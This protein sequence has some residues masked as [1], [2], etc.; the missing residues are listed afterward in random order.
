MKLRVYSFILLLGCCSIPQLSARTLQYLKVTDYTFNNLPSKTDTSQTIKFS[1]QQLEEITITATPLHKRLDALPG[2]IS[3][4]GPLNPVTD[5]STSI[6]TILEQVPGI[7]MQAGSFNTARI[8]IRGI[9]SRSPYATNRIRAFLNEIPL[10]GGDG[11]TIV[12]DLEIWETE[13]VEIIRGPS[14]ALYGPGL[15]GTLVFR[16]IGNLNEKWGGHILTEAGSFNFLKTGAHLGYRDSLKTLQAGIYRTITD[17]YRQ[18]NHYERTNAIIRANKQFYRHH[19]SFLVNHVNLFAQIPSS[20]NHEMYMNNPQKAA[21]NW[22]AVKGFQQY[23]KWQ[24]G[25]TLN[26]QI[27]PTTQNYFSAYA[28]INKAYESRPFNILEEKT[29]TTGIRNRLVMLREKLATSVGFEFFAEKYRW[30]IY[31]TIGGTQ[32]ELQSKNHDQRY[33]ANL[34]MHIEWKP[35]PET[36]I[37]TGLN[38][39]MVE[40]RSKTTQRD[41]EGT[42]VAKY[43]GQF[44]FSPRVGIS[45]QT[46]PTTY[47]FLSAGHGFSVPSSEEA[48]LPDGSINQNLKPE[49]G[50]NMDL[51]IRTSFLNNRARL[52]ITAYRIWVKNLLITKRDTEDQF[53]GENA[54]KT[55]HQGIESRLLFDLIGETTGK[56]ARL[57][58]VLAHTFMNNFFVSFI[59]NNQNLKDKKLPGLPTSS[60][61]TQLRYQNPTGLE[62]VLQYTHQNSQYINDINTVTYPG[63]DL[64]DATGAYRLTKGRFKRL[65]FKAGIRNVFDTKHAS[66]LLVN[67]PSF[68]NTAPRYY[69]PG[70]PRN[71]Y[72]GFNYRFK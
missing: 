23:S 31:E 21:P 28:I 63:H 58:L 43:P 49:E 20:I 65:N 36:R 50:I 67:A 51:G 7:Q 38:F 53:Y 69:Y 62:L 13:K 19:I 24:N 22:L 52:E 40:Y 18:N 56:K 48:L 16:P 14:S 70:S 64:F 3:V 60:L 68:G 71:I 29:L 8:T 55:I 44:V 6:N 30:Q 26:S 61:N 5:Q 2:S 57:K 4:I 11:A 33:F 37:T 34:F 32:G 72:F 17:G 15:G 27:S 1:E 45:H 54:G 12:E 10:T 66:M 47:L 25:F 35:L 41:I 39:H 9:G 42:M 59:Q 46:G